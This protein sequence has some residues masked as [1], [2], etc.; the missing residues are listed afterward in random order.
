MINGRANKKSEEKNPTP[1]ELAL[2]SI[3][4]FAARRGEQ[5]PQELDFLPA[6]AEERPKGEKLVAGSHFVAKAPWMKS[7]ETLTV[8]VRLEIDGDHGASPLPAFH[9]CRLFRPF[10]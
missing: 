10:P 2:E 7:T 1:V 8:T 6:P 3:K 5:K 4:G 9:P